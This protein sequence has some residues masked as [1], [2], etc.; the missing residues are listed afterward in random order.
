[1][2]AVTKVSLFEK[3]SG[4]DSEGWPHALQIEFSEGRP[5]EIILKEQREYSQLSEAVRLL[6]EAI[7]K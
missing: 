6:N 2:K 7:L 4:N 3:R 5:L 1:M